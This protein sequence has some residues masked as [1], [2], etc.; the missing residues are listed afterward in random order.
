MH[1]KYKSKDG[2]YLLEVDYDSEPMNPRTEWDNS[3]IM[4]CYHKNYLLGDVE[5]SKKYK[6]WQDECSSWEEFGKLLKRETKA[7]CIMPLF[8]YDHSGI[9]M[10]TGS[11]Q[12]RWDSG[13]VGFAVL[14]SELLKKQGWTTK[15]RRN[16]LKANKDKGGYEE[17]IRSDVKTYDQYL[18][19]EIFRTTLHEIKKEVVGYEG[20]ISLPGIFEPWVNVYLQP[21]P[22]PIYHVE[23][24]EV[25]SCG[26]YYSVADIMSDFLPKGVE[27]EAIDDNCTLDELVQDTLEMLNDAA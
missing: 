1:S 8:L 19:G 16:W 25:D 5:E 11:F 21:N 15:M 3:T 24:E 4:Y 20:A 23:A 2:K 26:G 18:R 27:V 9:T 7:L 10:S 22:K 14:T 13:Q 17:L 6:W 12:D